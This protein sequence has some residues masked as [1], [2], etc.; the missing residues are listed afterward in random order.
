MQS[1]V[2]ALE[3]EN[4]DLMKELEYSR[5]RQADYDELSSELD[6]LRMEREELLRAA[7]TKLES[8]VHHS[9]AEVSLLS[10]SVKADPV[11]AAETV[12]A[13]E[14][15]L[16]C[17]REGQMNYHELSPELDILKMER[18]ELVQAA[19]NE[20]ERSI[21][22]SIA[23]V[24]LL[25]RSVKADPVIGDE[26]TAA[27][28]QTESS[29]IKTDI[30]ALEIKPESVDISCQTDVHVSYGQSFHIPYGLK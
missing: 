25:S 21:H 24:S 11:I 6:I 28:G 7:H 12:A 18:E 3:M 27:T 17:S 19:H 2:A 16:E 15:H 9:I 4:T 29:P 20:S 13:T 22:H 23:E 26:V 1:R 10:R 14:K 8:S 5:E 30:E